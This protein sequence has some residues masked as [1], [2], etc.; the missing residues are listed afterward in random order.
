MKSVAVIGQGFVG[1]TLTTV[2]AEHGA[3]PYVFDKTGKAATGGKLVTSHGETIRDFIGRMGHR[4]GFSCIFFVC[5]PTPM[6]PSGA[7]DTS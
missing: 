2:L 5:V 1:G 6:L 7:A 4:P 3:H